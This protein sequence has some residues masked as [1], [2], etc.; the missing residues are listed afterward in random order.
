[1]GAVACACAWPRRALFCKRKALN[2]ARGLTYCQHT[3]EVNCW[4]GQRML[5]SFERVHL[6]F[7]RTWSKLFRE[8]L[9]VF[10]GNT[11]AALLATRGFLRRLPRFQLINRPTFPRLS[12]L[13]ERFQLVFHR[14]FGFLRL[15]KSVPVEKK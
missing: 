6:A 11:N 14:I 9:D 8:R 10:E 1:M 12:L 7:S 4:L 13:G 5:L 2:F 15:L 3:G